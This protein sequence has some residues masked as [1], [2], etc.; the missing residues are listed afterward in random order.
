MIKIDDLL[1]MNSENLFLSGEKYRIN[2]GKSII[3]LLNV[4][5]KDHEIDISEIAAKQIENELDM[6]EGIL[7]KLSNQS[8]SC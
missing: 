7:I 8:R 4:L 5:S 6:E 1:L 3:E 2:T